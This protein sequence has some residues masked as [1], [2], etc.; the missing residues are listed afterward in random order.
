MGW[1]KLLLKKKGSWVTFIKVLYDYLYLKDVL[2][3]SLIFNKLL[4]VYT[5]CDLISDAV[6]NC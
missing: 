2:F 1:K 4:F 6:E 3:L 5:E